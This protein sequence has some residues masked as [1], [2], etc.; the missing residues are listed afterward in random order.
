M[1]L[2]KTGKQIGIVSGDGWT[3]FKQHIKIGVENEGL[4]T[5]KTFNTHLTRYPL[6]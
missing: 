6:H 4:P 1:K 2:E 5:K 3:N